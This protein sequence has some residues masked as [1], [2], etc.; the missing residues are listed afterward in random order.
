MK[1]YF[2]SQIHNYHL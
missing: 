2:I 1:C